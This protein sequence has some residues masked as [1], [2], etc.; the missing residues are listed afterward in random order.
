MREQFGSI[1]LAAYQPDPELFRSQLLSIRSQSI[2]DWECVITV[3]GDPRPIAE[4]VVSSTQGDPRFRVIGDGSRRGFILN[5][6]HGIRAVDPEAR[7]V[8]LS[9][10]DDEWYPHKLEVLL[11]HLTEVDLVSAQSRLVEKPSGRVLGVTSRHDPDLVGTLL[12]NQ[13]SGSAFVFRPEI[14]S[15]ALPFPTVSTRTAAHDHWLAVVAASGRGTR[16]LPDVLQD[17]VQH[18]GNVFGDPSG[19]TGP[20]GPLG[21]VRTA[22]DLA[23]KWEGSR[24]PFAL[25]RMVFWLNVGWRQLLADTLIQRTDLGTS[26]RLAEIDSYFSAARRFS[27]LHRLLRQA[28]TDGR[29]S[30]RFRLEYLASW[31]AGILVRGRALV[32]RVRG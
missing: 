10:Q 15:V 31:F 9:D 1:V 25:A 12:D 5:F 13:F 26:A 17:Y 32:R 6:E 4:L 27:A 2:E 7:W 30:R 24:S 23:Q 18:Q 14:L 28:V 21:S 22:F 11:P 8:A 29:V 20:G 16:M 19:M 3:D